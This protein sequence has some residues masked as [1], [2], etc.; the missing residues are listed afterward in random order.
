MRR[1]FLLVIVWLA[2]CEKSAGQSPAGQRGPMKFPVEVMAVAPQR[3]EYTINAVGSVDAFEK[4]QVTARVAGAIDKLL[5]SEGDVVKQGQPLAEIEPQRYSVAVAQAKAAL[6]KAVAARNDAAAGLKRREDAVAQNPGLLSG[7]EVETF[8]TRQMSAQAD[9][10]AARAALDRAQIDLRD[11]YV[12]S[13]IPGII[14][15]RVVQTG[16][17]LQPGTV[18]ATIVRREPL[19]LRFNVTESDAQRLKTKMLVRFIVRSDEKEYAALISHVGGAADPQSRMVAV[20]AEIGSD[21]PGPAGGAE[22]AKVTPPVDLSALRPG[23]FAEVTVP[24]SN[25]GDAAVVPQQAIRASER[26]LLA[27]V[28]DGDIAHE[29]QVKLGMKTSD[30]KVEVLGGLKPGELLVVRGAEALREGAKVQVAGKGA[31]A[32]T[33]SDGGP[34][35]P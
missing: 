31:P 21:S 16:Q 13:P 2:A 28:V 7:E 22:G 25:R 1:L 34:A 29:R 24:V 23:A 20:T 17:Y 12:R 9:E 4:V 6:A 3:V 35:K 18:L 30:G 33:G 19:L 14:E 32:Q 15:T 27:F 10:Q 11:A 5:F 8:R 26:G